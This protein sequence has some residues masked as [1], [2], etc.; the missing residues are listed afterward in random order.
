[1]FGDKPKDFQKAME[2]EQVKRCSSNCKVEPKRILT[3]K[4]KDEAKKREEWRKS[5]MP[6]EEQ[7]PAA[8]SNPL[9]DAALNRQGRG[10]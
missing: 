10:Y 4:E 5:L 1:M 6:K 2:W 3:D 8:S 7:K 9:R